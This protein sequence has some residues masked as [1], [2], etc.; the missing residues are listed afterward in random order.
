MSKKDIKLHPGK[1]KTHGGYSFLVKGRLPENRANVERYLTGAREGLIQNLGPTEKDLT[2]AQLILI[3]RITVKLGVVRCMEEHVRENEVMIGSRLVPSLRESYLAYNNSIRLDLAALGIDKRQTE[4]FD[5]KE[6]V[7]DK[8]GDDEK[9]KH[10][11]SD[12]R[13]RSQRKQ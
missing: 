7:A 3:D 6:Y 2:T 5:L 13:G 9:G 10:S 11:K 12:S 4:A 1:R 8:Y